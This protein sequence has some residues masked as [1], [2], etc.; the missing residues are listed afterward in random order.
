MRGGDNEWS[1]Q[2]IG[3]LQAKYPALIVIDPKDAQCSER[4]CVTI[5]DGS[6]VYRDVGHLTDH[7]SHKFGE[8]YLQRIG[9][10][11]R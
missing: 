2:V 7:A 10:P 3:L 8:M 9:N 4:E 5:I 6:P 1:D 11:F